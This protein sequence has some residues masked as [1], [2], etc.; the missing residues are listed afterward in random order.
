MTER[1]ILDEFFLI[2]GTRE[3]SLDCQYQ[4]WDALELQCV[5][6]VVKFIPQ[7]LELLLS[8]NSHYVH[9]GSHFAVVVLSHAVKITGH[10]HPL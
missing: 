6:Q 5:L 3:V 10:L 7:S 2:Q 8:S 1:L 9:N 4:D